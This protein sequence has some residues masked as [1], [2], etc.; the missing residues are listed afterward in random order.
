[1][2]GEL[3]FPTASQEKAKLRKAAGSKAVKKVKIVEDHCD[4]LGDDLTGLGGDIELYAADITAATE[5]IDSDDP[6]A[7]AIV[8]VHNLITFWCLGRDCSYPSTSS[9]HAVNCAQLT[10]VMESI[11]TPPLLS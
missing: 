10:A 9:Y 6:D 2:Q 4:D 1:M 3:A 11:G 5:D 7:C 8:A